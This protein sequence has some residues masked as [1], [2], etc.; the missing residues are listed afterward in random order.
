MAVWNNNVW[1]KDSHDQLHQ[2][3]TSLDMT[4]SYSGE[5]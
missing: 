1:N 4:I 5:N 2:N 3:L